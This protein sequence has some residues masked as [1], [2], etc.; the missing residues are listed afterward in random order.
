MISI[1]VWV[2]VVLILLIII[3][4][5]WASLLSRTLV[6]TLE[7]VFETEEKRRG[8]TTPEGKAQLRKEME[9]MFG[10]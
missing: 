3:L 1:P 8:I 2:L 9:S 5:S 7:K 6:N 4:F 10:N